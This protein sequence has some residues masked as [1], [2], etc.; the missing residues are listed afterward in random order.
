MDLVTGPVPGLTRRTAIPQVSWDT[1]SCSE[2]NC[3]TCGATY[4]TGVFEYLTEDE[5]QSLLV[6][7]E[8]HPV[9]LDTGS[10]PLKSRTFLI[11]LKMNVLAEMEVGAL[12]V[13][14][15]PEHPCGKRVRIARPLVHHNRNVNVTVGTIVTS[16]T[17]SIEIDFQD[18]RVN[19]CPRNN[20]LAVFV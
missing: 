7:V 9:A 8:Q 4:D 14:F 12:F 11:P 17:T 6:G 16:C 1:T 20:L 3:D 5:I 2:F 13:P 19:R 18:F 15:V 10:D